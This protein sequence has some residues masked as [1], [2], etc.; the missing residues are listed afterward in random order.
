MMIIFQTD[1]QQTDGQDDDKLYM[2]SEHRINKRNMNTAQ[3]QTSGTCVLTQV[4]CDLSLYYHIMC[5]TH[6]YT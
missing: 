5:Q 1:E 3:Q 4:H 2:R 6:R